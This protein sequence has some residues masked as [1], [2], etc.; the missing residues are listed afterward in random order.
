MIL[1]AVVIALDFRVGNC[2]VHSVAACRRLRRHRDL[3]K[4]QLMCRELVPMVNFSAQV[5]NALR[6][7]LFKGRPVAPW[8]CAPLTRYTHA[9]AS[10]RPLSNSLQNRC[11]PTEVTAS[12]RV[13]TTFTCAKRNS[14]TLSRELATAYQS[15]THNKH[16]LYA[17][18]V[19]TP[20]CSNERTQ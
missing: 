7:D 18:T 17:L 20:Y 14:A 8:L 11:S 10:P 19:S 16:A 4:V 13:R 12:E 2:Y 1:L 6:C 9:S 5:L 15:Q 3:E